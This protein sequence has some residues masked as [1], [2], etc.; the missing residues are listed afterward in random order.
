MNLN[1]LYEVIASKLRKENQ[2]LTVAP[3]A[4]SYQNQQAPFALVEFAQINWENLPSERKA[5]TVSVVLH[6]GYKIQQAQEVLSP[7]PNRLMARLAELR[8]DGEPLTHQS[9]RFVFEGDLC[10]YQSTFKALIVQELRQ[11]INA[12]VKLETEN[13]VVNPLK[14]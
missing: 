11:W 1:D 10:V 3:F 9:D 13:Y 14:P 2:I 12:P 7:L 5:G 8:I 4:G 6:T